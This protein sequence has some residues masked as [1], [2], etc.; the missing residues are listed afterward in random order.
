M[1]MQ[2]VRG[3]ASALSGASLLL[4]ASGTNA[5]RRQVAALWLRMFSADPHNAGA[6]SDA[7]GAKLVH[8]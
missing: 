8:V 5:S 6:H 2:K 7:A 1:Q 4:G 3:Y